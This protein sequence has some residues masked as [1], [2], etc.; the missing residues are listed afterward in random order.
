MGLIKGAGI[1]NLWAL[2]P[3]LAQASACALQYK[4]GTQRM[5]NSVA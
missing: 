4:C 1:A 5:L 2:L 3:I